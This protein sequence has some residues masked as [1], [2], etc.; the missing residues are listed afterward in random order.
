MLN[1]INLISLFLSLFFTGCATSLPWP[2]SPLYETSVT[3]SMTP[4]TR[5]EAIKQIVGHYAHFDIVSYEDNSARQPM[6]T[7]IVSYGFTDFYE[8]DGVLFEL[9]RFCHAKQQINYTSVRSQFPDVATQAIVPVPSPVELTYKN[10]QWHLFRPAT[11]TLL[12]VNGDSS[13]SFADHF[14]AFT[15]VDDDND[16]KPGVTVNLTIGGFMK[17]KIYIARREIFE[18]HL[19]WLSPERIEGYVLDRSEQK[20][21]GA[22]LFF[23]N[24]PSD[25]VQIPD[26]AM[27]PIHLIKIPES[28]D[29]CEELM[30]RGSEWFPQ[31]PAFF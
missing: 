14:E 19:V 5:A 11:P 8:Q 10:G 3:T 6:R 23:L 13:L 16:G 29:T 18:N 4:Q 28:V 20:V 26:P 27:N 9:D 7:F 25:P 17:G 30:A 22:S 24:K 31:A 2:Q 15:V 1:R 21:L 12:G